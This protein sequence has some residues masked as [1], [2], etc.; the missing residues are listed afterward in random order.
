LIRR[1]ITPDAPRI[2]RAITTSIISFLPFVALCSSGQAAEIITPP[3]N[4]ATKDHS[5]MMVT[6]ILISHPI[7]FGKASSCVAEISFSESEISFLPNSIQFPIKGTLVLSSIPQ[8]T[9]GSEQGTHF[10]SICLVH[11]G[12][13]HIQRVFLEAHITSHIFVFCDTCCGDQY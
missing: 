7:S 1:K 13:L 8:Q 5:I 3:A 6:N 4:I 12:H 9:H 2:A 11:F 10:F